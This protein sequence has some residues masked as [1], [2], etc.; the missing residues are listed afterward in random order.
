MHYLLKIRVSRC[1]VG[2]PEEW[3]ST[4]TACIIVCWK[5]CNLPVSTRGHPC[6]PFMITWTSRVPVANQISLFFLPCETESVPSNWTNHDQPGIFC[7]P[8]RLI[9]C[10][11]RWTCEK[12]S[13]WKER[14]ILPQQ[15][16]MFEKA[17]ASKDAI[18]ILHPKT[19]WSKTFF[20]ASNRLSLEEAAAKAFHLETTSLQDLLDDPSCTL[21]L[22]CKKSINKN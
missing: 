1:Y 19:P 6:H 7:T 4:G 3:L 18:P 15:E 8:S 12:D 2:L 17:N 9:L 5:E 14:V 11:V 21:I 20:T 16:N 10:K 13:Q 22:I